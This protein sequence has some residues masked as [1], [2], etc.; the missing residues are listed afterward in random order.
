MLR[1]V[2]AAGLSVASLLS[3]SVSVA[4][5]DSE[6]GPSADYTGWYQTNGQNYWYEHGSPARSKEIYDPGSNAWYWLDSDGTMARNKDVYLPSSGGKWV[7]YDENGHM[8]KGEDYRYGGWYY[9]D[10][11]TGAMAKG[12]RF[13]PSN[14]GKWVY[15]DW[16]TGKMAHGEQYVDYDA[17]HTGWY[18]FD[19]N[20]GAM[21]HG[22]TYVPSSG[23]KWVRYDRATGKMV[24]GLQAQDGA[25]YYFDQATGAMAHGNAWVP[26]WNKWAHFDEVTGRYTG[27]GAQPSPTP[28]PAPSQPDNG[29]NNGSNVYYKNCAAVRAAGKAPLYRGQPGYRPELDRDNDGIACE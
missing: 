21:F 15:Y 26:E 19:V 17:E 8:R 3:M 24:K 5:A 28:N 1:T 11:V 13:V 12:M 4:Y 23:G 6:S 27:D 22:D 18:L 25:W 20:T 16:T 10:P 9:F 2:I 7:R 14:G 29:G